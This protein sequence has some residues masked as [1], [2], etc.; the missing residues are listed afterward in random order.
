MNSNKKN[1][2]SSLI[3]NFTFLITVTIGI[4]TRF[5]YLNQPMKND[6]AYNFNHFVLAGFKN[7][8]SEYTPNNHIFHTLLVRLSYLTLGP[9]PWKIRLPAFIAGIIVIILTYLFFRFYYNERVALLASGLVATSPLPIDFS[10]NARGYTLSILFFLLIFILSLS[11]AQSRNFYKSL[12]K[13]LAFSVASALGFYTIPT[14]LYPFGVVCMWWLFLILKKEP[15]ERIKFFLLLIALVA[16]TA[17]L[18]ALLYLPVVLNSGIEVLISNPTVKPLPRVDFWERLKTSWKPNWLLL[19][20]GF[21]TLISEVLLAGFFLSFLNRKLTEER[22]DYPNLFLPVILFIVPALFIQKVVPYARVWLFLYP[23]YFGLSAVGLAGAVDFIAKIAKEDFVLKKIA[24]PAVV[25]ILVVFLCFYLTTNNPSGFYY[26]EDSSTF[27]RDGKVVA[28][29]LSKNLEPGTKI[30]S[31]Q[32]ANSVLRYY[33]FLYKLTQ[34]DFISLK[35]KN[36]FQEEISQ[37][38][39]IILVA[40]QSDSINKFKQVFNQFGQKI[41]DYQ[42]IRLK[43]FNEAVLYELKKLSEEKSFR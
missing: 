27:F 14:F 3:S 23:I 37:S 24:Y 4:F 20:L 22:K 28:L 40:R 13:S 21:P 25:L 19:N 42:F 39:R 34:P 36:T 10:A 18:T 7:I 17:L 16:I 32:P 12:S 33:I 35:D 1:K 5:H 15:G 38:D 6:E 8:I 9:E 30:L 26:P 41:D 43:T 11:I 31:M 2:I 29:F